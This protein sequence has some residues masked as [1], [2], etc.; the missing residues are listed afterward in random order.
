YQVKD[1]KDFLFNVLD[2]D[3]TLK[4]VTENAERGVVGQSEIDFVLLEGRSEIVA[5]VQAQIQQIMD[6][7][8]VGIQVTAVNLQDAQPPNEEV[9][10]AFLDVIKAREDKQRYVREAEAYMNDIVPKAR[11]RASRHILEAQ[12][13][14]TRVVEEAKGEAARF[15]ALLAAY[16]RAPEVTRKRLY[17]ESIENVLSHTETILVDVDKSN[18]L[19]YLPLDRP[20]SKLPDITSEKSTD[21]ARYETSDSSDSGS[22]NT[23]TSSRGR[24][25]RGRQ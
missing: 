15:E 2:P 10:K 22:I 3:E 9:Q 13:Y 20:A 19:L 8:N 18:N 24:E 17:I 21:P 11:G 1:A 25:G 5:Q 6:E 23:R 7:Y 4:Q 12:A 16:N 14:K